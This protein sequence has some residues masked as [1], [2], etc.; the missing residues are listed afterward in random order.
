LRGGVR[1]YDC[2]FDDA[3]LAINLVQTMIELGGTAVNY[4][5]VNGLLKNEG[6][7]SGVIAEDLENG[8]VTKIEARVVINAT[9]VFVD[10]VIKM[11]DPEARDQVKPSQGIHLVMDDGFLRGR[12]ALMIPKTTDG[13]VLFAVPWHG[14]VVVGTTDVEKQEA[15]LEPIAEKGEV[16]YIL[17][18]AGRFMQPAPEKGDVLSVF[19]G[20][21]PLA[22]PSGEGKKTKEI[23]RG[24]KVLV[25]EGG[26]VTLTGGKWTTYRKMG[27][28]V[29]DRAA[30]IAGLPVRKSST[31]EMK[32]H[33]HHQPVDHEDPLYWYGVDREGIHGLMEQDPA[34]AEFVSE[35]LQIRKVQILWAI[36][37]EMART[38]E[39][40]LARRTRALQLDA[41]ECIR[42]APQVA[43]I[44]AAELSHDQEW[45]TRQVTEFTNLARQ[46]LLT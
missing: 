37:E 9:G 7:V 16:D 33:G 2:Q 1:Y 3:R 14:H 23:S 32:I 24:H 31:S 34:L 12:E 45:E 40:C 39:D 19:T 13:R 30:E 42:V 44:M 43:A 29:V 5:K 20:L 35:K 4:L 25:S 27:E 18:T 6:K 10:H 22:A 38:V 36:R 41:R 15:V 17:E 26:L 11:D 8:K 46:Y 21:R 28:D